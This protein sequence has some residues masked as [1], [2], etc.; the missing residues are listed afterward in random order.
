META[1]R[2]LMKLICAIRFYTLEK[3]LNSEY[4]AEHFCTYFSDSNE[5]EDAFTFSKHDKDT[6]IAAASI[7]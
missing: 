3:D 4:F 5:F 7:T 2:G 1:E 6:R